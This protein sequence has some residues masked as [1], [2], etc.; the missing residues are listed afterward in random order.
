MRVQT[1][2]ATLTLLLVLAA[3]P[4]ATSQKPAAPAKAAD[5]VDARLE[6][7]KS[8]RRPTSTGCRRSR[9]RWSTRSSASASWASRSSRRRGT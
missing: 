4:S 5:P 7:L 3:M 2:L 9:S 6:K 1:R 8:R